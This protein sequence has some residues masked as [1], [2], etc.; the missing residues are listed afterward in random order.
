MIPGNENQTV[1]KSTRFLHL[2]AIRG[3]YRAGMKT[4]LQTAVLV[5]FGV[6]ALLLAQAGGVESYRPAVGAAPLAAIPLSRKKQCIFQLWGAGG[7]T[8]ITSVG[9]ASRDDCR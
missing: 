9:Q 4:V 6:W 3:T 1:I 2:A 5:M 8:G 7:E